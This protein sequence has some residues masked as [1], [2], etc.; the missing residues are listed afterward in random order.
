M[1]ERPFDG[2]HV[3]LLSGDIGK[4]GNSRDNS[5][6]V[7]LG[8][9][10]ATIDGVHIAHGRAD[11][12]DLDAFGGGV[13]SSF[14]S[15]TTFRDVTFFENAAKVNHLV[16]S[17]LI[18]TKLGGARDS[19]GLAAVFHHNTKHR[20]S[21]VPARRRTRHLPPPPPPKSQIPNP[22]SARRRD[23][24]LDLHEP[25]H[26]RLPLHQQLGVR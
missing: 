10:A 14:F 25:A 5:Y 21:V 7:V 26:P 1:S 12:D 4:M 23:V 20:Q 3:T 16:Y 22:K 8:A 19:G 9:H 17:P 11:G 6:H 15:S 18:P 2:N 24:Q 13:L